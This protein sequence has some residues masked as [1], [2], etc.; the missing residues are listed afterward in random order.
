MLNLNYLQQPVS[1]SFQTTSHSSQVT[2]ITQFH[3]TKRRI[4][5]YIIYLAQFDVIF[6]SYATI[7]KYAGVCERQVQRHMSTLIKDGYISKLSRPNMPNIYTLAD[8]FY[9]EENSNYLMQLLPGLEFLEKK[10]KTV[11]IEKPVLKTKSAS[12]VTLLNVSYLFITNN[13]L[14]LSHLARTSVRARQSWDRF[15]KRKSTMSKKEILKQLKFSDEEV[16]ILSEYDETVLIQAVAIY[17]SSRGVLAPFKYFEG[18]CKKKEAHGAL[19]KLS[20]QRTISGSSVFKQK[21]WQEEEITPEQLVRLQE[22]LKFAKRNVK[23]GKTS[24]NLYPTDENRRWLNDYETQLQQREEAL[25]SFL[26]LYEAKF[27]KTDTAKGEAII[28]HSAQY[29]HWVKYF[30]ECMPD[31][32]KEELINKF[33]ANPKIFEDNPI[34]VEVLRNYLNNRQ[35]TYPDSSKFAINLTLEERF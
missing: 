14:S 22:R 27:G 11:L 32:I 30:S 3:S 35:A 23:N 33:I 9:I 20:G 21:V 34:V 19:E 16:E 31:Q 7:A 17:K 2:A 4:L 5:N 13:N 18:I 24:L 15:S 8:L 12:H 10:Q 28:T 1:N 6:P 25:A 26:P 29:D